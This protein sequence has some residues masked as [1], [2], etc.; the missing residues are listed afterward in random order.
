MSWCYC[1]R[2]LCRNESGWHRK[3]PRFPSLIYCTPAP[4]VVATASHV[5]L[6]P[7]VYLKLLQCS[8][9]HQVPERSKSDSLVTPPLAKSIDFSTL[10]LRAGG[11]HHVTTIILASRHFSIDRVFALHYAV[12]FSYFSYRL[13]TTL[14]SYSLVA[15]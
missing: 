3:Q 7:L 1:E 5:L 2:G 14:G 12:P 11:A 13:N 4:P 10:I 8:G 6:P 9:L 15:V